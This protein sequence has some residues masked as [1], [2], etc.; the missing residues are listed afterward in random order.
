MINWDAAAPIPILT[1][2]CL[3]LNVSRVFYKIYKVSISYPIYSVPI[4]LLKNLMIRFFLTHGDIGISQR[5]KNLQP[6]TRR[7]ARAP[8]IATVGTGDPPSPRRL[9]CIMTVYSP[10]LW[11]LEA[12]NHMQAIASISLLTPAELSTERWLDF[13]LI[14]FSLL[15]VSMEDCGGEIRGCN[16]YSVTGS[17]SYRLWGPWPTL[18]LLPFFTESAYKSNKER[19]RKF[20]SKSFHIY[21]DISVR[22]SSG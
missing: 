7:V 2:L 13:P 12:P 5:L 14:P 17:F 9:L 18:N 15:P 11:K 1:L 4:C 22:A 21:K 16:C 6:S 8:L 19:I 3:F 20:P 10:G